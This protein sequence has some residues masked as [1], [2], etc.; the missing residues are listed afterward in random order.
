MKKRN[1]N[2]EH[3]DARTNREG[4]TER[5]KILK[6]TDTLRVVKGVDGYKQELDSQDMM[7]NARL[8]WKIT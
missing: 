8:E 3:L 5:K 1:N 2:G 6:Y 4:H 7:K